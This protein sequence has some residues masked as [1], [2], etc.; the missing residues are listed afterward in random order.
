M[1]KFRHTNEELADAKART[2]KSE[3]NRVWS[4][5]RFNFVSNEKEVEL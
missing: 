2:I 3:L 5:K 4:T 1:K